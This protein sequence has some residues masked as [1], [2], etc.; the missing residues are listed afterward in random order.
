MTIK[1]RKIGLLLW[2]L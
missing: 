2:N 1:G